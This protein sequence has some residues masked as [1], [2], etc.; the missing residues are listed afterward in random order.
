MNEI[1]KYKKIFL[2]SDAGDFSASYQLFKMYSEGV[3]VNSD[4]E[5]AD[6]YK[7]KFVEQ[8]GNY[9]FRI[10]SVR[11]VNFKGFN[12]IDL[13]FN[14]HGC[15]ILVGNN[16]S[17]KSTV[18]EAIQK[19]LSHLSSRLT[20]RSYNGDQIDE[21]EIK[22]RSEYSTVA[23]N[24]LINELNINVELSQSRPLSQIIKKSKFTELNDLG[25]IFRVANSMVEGFPLP[26]LASYN[27]ERANDVTTKDI[28]KSEEILDSYIWNKS[29]GYAKSLTGKADFRLFFKWF[30]EVTEE[31][32]ENS[33][34]ELR[35]RISEKEAEL[36]SP[37]LQSIFSDFDNLNDK[38]KS[39]LDKYRKDIEELR[40]NLNSVSTDKTN[41]R[42]LGFVKDAI[43][44]FLPG[45]SDLKIQRNPLDLTIRKNDEQLSVLQL[46]QGEKSL[47]ALVADIARRLTLLN[48]ERDNPLDGVGVVLIDEI[49]LHL[50]PS[51]QQ[52]IVSRLQST[53]KN[54]QFI[55]TTHSPQVCHAVSSDNIWLLKD[56]EKFK[57][58]RGVQGAVSSWVLKNLFQVEVRPPEDEFAKMLK[59]YEELVYADKYNSERAVKLYEKLQENF[60]S[61]YD[62]FVQ[63]RLY[64]ENREWEK[65]FDKD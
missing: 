18:L 21:L 65:E 38:V 49:D 28:E 64:K 6:Y 16:G 53:F 15:T 32:N 9:T 29:R 33:L 12:D 10:S 17:G 63:L 2:K 36:N 54:I 56:G 26:L 58:P 37:L 30:K 46:S 59:E 11:L 39:T 43:Y 25:N 57:A 14:K 31:K 4:S 1:A 60:G 19:T 52:V 5:K 24:F 44:K 8:L 55:I 22:S 61:D 13:P 23:V 34:N 42:L 62:F 51:W 35:L 7:K 41:E 48:P 40:N 3:G 47:L 27:V 45:F 20:T 50:H